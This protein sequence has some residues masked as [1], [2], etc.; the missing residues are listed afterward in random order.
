VGRNADL[1]ESTTCS[2]C[3]GST[4]ARGKFING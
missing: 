2:D 4:G 1:P 3:R